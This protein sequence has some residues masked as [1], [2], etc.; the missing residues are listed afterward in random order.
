MTTSDLSAANKQDYHFDVFLDDD[1]IGSHH[2]EIS[3]QQD[4][5]T[6]ITRADFEY[7]ILFIPVYSYEH[8]TIETWRDG[9][10][11]AINS[12]TDDN[13]DE[14]FIKG[15][16]IE[17]GLSVETREGMSEQQGCIR[18]FAYWDHDLL[19]S[20]RLLNTQNGGYQKSQLVEL[21]RSELEIDDDTSIEAIK[22]QLDSE[23]G[24][25]TLWYDEEDNWLALESKVDNS[26]TIRYL[27]TTIPGD[28]S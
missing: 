11:I 17:N 7:R 1:R 28:R 27:S 2:V 13:G 20:D 5:T 10:V 15:K 4:I 12:S 26:S 3:T 21:G 24:V 19:F 8:Q 22:Y 18:T 23:E 9:C 16:A 14:F 6:V 25:I